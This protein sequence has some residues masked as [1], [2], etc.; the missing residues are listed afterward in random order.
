MLTKAD[1]N[2]E[3]KAQL[4]GILEKHKHEIKGAASN[5]KQGNQIEVVDQIQ[6]RGRGG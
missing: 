2:G 5:H 1:H 3:Q 6:R 4:Q